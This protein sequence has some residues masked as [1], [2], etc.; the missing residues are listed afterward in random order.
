MRKTLFIEICNY[1]D[2]PLGGQLSCALHFTSAM[3]G[4]IDLVGCRTDSLY[5]EGQW[6]ECMINGYMYHF[7]NAGNVVANGG[8]PFI[9]ARITSYIRMK[10]YI[11]QILLH[12]EYDIIILQ[13]PEVLM[14]IPRKYL[15]KVCLIMPGVGN[16]LSISRYKWARRL[17]KLYDK[18]FF[19]FAK[20][21]NII[22]PAA[23]TNA[24]N[25]FVRRSKGLID[26]TKVVQFPTRYDADIFKPIHSES[27]RKELHMSDD[28]L[29]IVTSGR[30]NW[31]KGWKYMIDAFNIFKR[32]HEN[33]KLYFIGKGEDE[34]KIRTYIKD[35][36]LQDSV[37]LAG[38][39]PLTVVSK[40]LNTADLFIMGSYTEGWSTALVEAIACSNPCVVTD[41]S[42][43]RDLVHDGENG[44]VQCGRD[45]NEFA[46][47]MEKALLLD[48]SVVAEYASKAY[49]MSVQTM[50]EQLN[51]I[52]HFE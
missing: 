6:C 18:I 39:H 9:P 37:I 24:I 15:S 7:F 14:S 31:F 41:F 38:V 49:L 2:Y 13:A 5:P 8:K 3:K 29:A 40:Y 42:S 34:E 32:T 28:E 33:A 52:I 30:L 16:P 22:L 51:D 23:D 50:R 4:D 27:F 20:D 10:K 17:A 26:N 21:V 19:N 12:K 46:H 45:E 35:L 36:S 44:Y 1:K 25:A 11:K 43:A 48:P 47:L